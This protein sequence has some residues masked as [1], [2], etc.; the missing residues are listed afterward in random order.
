MN[1]I[2]RYTAEVGKH[3]PRKM[4]ADIET[5]IR[6]TLEDML[7]ERSQKAGRPTDDEMVKDLLKE[8]G[9]PDKVA[10]TYLP[11]RYL[12]GPKLFP[13]FTLVLKIVFSVLTA[14][15]LIGFGI[16]FGQSEMTA[17]AFGAQLSDTDIAAVVAY[18]RNAWTNKLGEVIQPAEVKALRGK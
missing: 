9:A 7:E 5:E 16:H 3:L 6:S 14:L 2:E 12:I 18:E 15:A 17:A 13:I 10:A 4:R 1:L 11:E 8:Y